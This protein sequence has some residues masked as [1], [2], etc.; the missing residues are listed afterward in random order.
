M[1]GQTHR[2]KQL[3]SPLLWQTVSPESAIVT[4]GTGAAAVRGPAAGSPAGHGG[5]SRRPTAPEA[6]RA[7]GEPV[8]LAMQPA[9]PAVSRRSEAAIQWM[10]PFWWQSACE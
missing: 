10:Q 4:T 8:H 7:A 9:S 2:G 5:R 3:L 1:L 6:A